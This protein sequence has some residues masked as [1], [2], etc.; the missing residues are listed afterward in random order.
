MDSRVFKATSVL[1]LACILLL[2][3]TVCAGR[4]EARKYYYNGSTIG[5]P[6]VTPNYYPQQNYPIQNNYA[7]TLHRGL[8]FRNTREQYFGPDPSRYYSQQPQVNP[9]YPY[10]GYTPNSTG[11]YIPGTQFNYNYGFDSGYYNSRNKANSII[12][13]NT[14]RDRI[15]PYEVRR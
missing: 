7:N 4:V 3:A 5:G 1:G 10:G 8:G 14:S 13:Y 15:R 12:G 11:G 9:Y 6:Y 2:G